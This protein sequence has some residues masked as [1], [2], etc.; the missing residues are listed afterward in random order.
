MIVYMQ[1]VKDGAIS[2]NN[3]N[4]CA[5]SRPGDRG[6]LMQSSFDSLLVALFVALSPAEHDG[7]PGIAAA[8]PPRPGFYQ[9]YEWLSLRPVPSGASEATD[10][11]Y[12][13]DATARDNCLIR[14]TRASSKTGESILAFPDQIIWIAPGD[15]GMPFK[16]STNPGR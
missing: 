8:D 15:P 10:C 5:L 6:R 1:K 2:G 14:T 3:G 9:D 7:Q 11:R 12:F 13:V 4:E 16:F